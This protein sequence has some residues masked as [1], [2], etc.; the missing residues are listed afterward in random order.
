MATASAASHEPAPRT[1]GLMQ[2]NVQRGAVCAAVLCA[3]VL[4]AACAA[5]P[6]AQPSWPAPSDPMALAA[7]AGL[8]PT[9]RE[10][11][12]THT[13]SHLDV[14]VDGQK[15]VVPAGIGIDIEAAAGVQS[16]PS[17][18]GTST[19]YYVTICGAP[20]L[21]PLHTHDA[22]GVIHTESRNPHENPYTLGQFFTEWGI[23]LDDSCVGDFCKPNA[24]VV[25]YLDGKKYDGNPAE[26]Q[27]KSH[28][29]IAIVIGKPPAVIPDHWDFGELP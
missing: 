10:Y 26:I 15:V 2:G 24:S 7:Q 11:L 6:L 23:R 25:L 19:E 9:D 3:V 14:L 8:E 22:S 21:S 18:D 16:T 4:V 1:L 28:I 13:H 29:E 12:M 27:L 20:C 5:Q 17:A